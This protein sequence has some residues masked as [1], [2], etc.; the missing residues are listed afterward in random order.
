MTALGFA[1]RLLVAEDDPDLLY[2]VQGALE[3]EGYGVTPATSLSASLAALE[4]HLFHFVLTDLFHYHGQTPLLSIQPLLQAAAPIPVGVMTA[5]PVPEEA[6]T[7]TTLA[8]LLR[9]PFEID[10]LLRQMDAHIHPHIRSSRQRS[11]V[12]DFFL[13]LNA[14]DMTLLE[15]LCTPDAKVAPPLAGST[16]S[17]RLYNHLEALEHRWSRLPGYTIE[18]VQLFDYLDGVAARCLGRW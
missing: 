2:L 6:L 17:L 14:H 18:E 13:A 9:K 4:T 1:P 7:Q 15:R 5:W 10:D 16:V 8:F 3:E 12:Q 11:L